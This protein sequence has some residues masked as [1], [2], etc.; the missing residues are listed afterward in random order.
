MPPLLQLL[1][2]KLRMWV[3]CSL[4]K[5]LGLLDLYSIQMTSWMTTVISLGESCSRTPL[6]NMLN[7]PN[8]NFS[9][10][11]TGYHF[12]ARC[13]LQWLSPTTQFWRLT[14]RWSTPTAPSWWTTRPS[15]TSA[16]GTWTLRGRRTPTWI[17]WLV[18]L[19]PLSQHP[20]GNL[21]TCL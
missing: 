17:V 3:A 5:T 13:P 4:W 21:D 10:N 9:Q 6:E 7:Y 20:W 18:R 11:L 14:P 19:S 12:V 8:P 2:T 16:A 15:M 1:S